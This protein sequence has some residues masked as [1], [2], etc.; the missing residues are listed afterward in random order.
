MSFLRR[1]PSNKKIQRIWFSL[2]LSSLSL[3][4]WYNVLHYTSV[5]SHSIYFSLQHRSHV[6]WFLSLQF[7]IIRSFENISP[8]AIISNHTVSQLNINVHSEQHKIKIQATQSQ[9]HDNYSTNMHFTQKSETESTSTSTQ[10]S[11][12]ASA[13]ICSGMISKFSGSQVLILWSTVTLKPPH[14]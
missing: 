6:W 9:S 12:G 5:I 2:L 13:T 3:H 10:G 1:N 8:T 7:I 11:I 14:Q 4:T